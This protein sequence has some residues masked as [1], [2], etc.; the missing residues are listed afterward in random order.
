MG[1][2]Y[3]LREPFTKSYDEKIRGFGELFEIESVEMLRKKLWRIYGDEYP[4]SVLYLE[5]KGEHS[6][7]YTLG[8]TDI[9]F[10]DKVIDAGD[11]DRPPWICNPKIDGKP[12]RKILMFL[13]RCVFKI[14]VKFESKHIW[15]HPAHIS[16]VLLKGEIK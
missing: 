1:K 9:E 14:L 11:T 8:V 6:L 10:Y 3:P 15:K 5:P 13:A 12:P 16:Y 7:R 2:L 4:Y